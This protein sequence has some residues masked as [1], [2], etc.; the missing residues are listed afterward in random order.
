MKRMIHSSNLYW[1]RPG[2][3]DGY[4]LVDYLL[5]DLLCPSANPKSPIE[6]NHFVLHQNL[7]LSST[8]IERTSNTPPSHIQNERWSSASSHIA[9]ALDATGSNRSS[10]LSTRAKRGSPE[11]EDGLK[12]CRLWSG[13]SFDDLEC[14]PAG[15]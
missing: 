5:H 2:R 15:F 11:S 1:N 12:Y 4:I 10:P 9:T 3:G 8:G 6:K 14:M 7:Q 13:I